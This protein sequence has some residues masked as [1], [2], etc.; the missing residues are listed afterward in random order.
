MWSL[1]L[2]LAAVALSNAP[3]ALARVGH[4][5]AHG[6]ALPAHRAQQIR[7]AH[8]TRRHLA[9]GP[10]KDIAGKLGIVEPLFENFKEKVK[11]VE[12]AALR[13]E[14]TKEY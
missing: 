9:G 2:A 13:N 8:H 7:K 5:H 4:H 14:R 10:G 6:P 11:Q 3:I 1:V 12:I